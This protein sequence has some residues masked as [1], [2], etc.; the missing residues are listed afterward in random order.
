[1]LKSGVRARRGHLVMHVCRGM[2]TDAAVVGLIVG[3]GVGGSVVRHQVSRRLRA[4][5]AERVERLPAGSGTVVR[6][7]PGAAADT[8]QRL[9]TDLDLLLGRLVEAST[10]ASNTGTPAPNGAR[11][12]VSSG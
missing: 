2:Q 4:Q 10:T 3:K 7:L 8:S 5:L 9:G 1:M 12:S 6:A 11:R